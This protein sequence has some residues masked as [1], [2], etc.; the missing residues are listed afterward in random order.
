MS[1][2][3]VKKQNTQTGC[4]VVWCGSNSSADDVDDDEGERPC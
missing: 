1:S 2:E 3:L 4:G